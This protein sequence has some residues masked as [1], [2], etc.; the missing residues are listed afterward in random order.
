VVV[1]AGS[2]Q[3]QSSTP[4]NTSD[5]NTHAR[6]RTRPR[7][8]SDA[9]L[10]CFHDLVGGRSGRGPNGGGLYAGCVVSTRTRS[11]APSTVKLVTA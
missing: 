6:A 8:P 4:L 9:V 10:P 5:P 11:S 7:C 2:I 1:I 3:V